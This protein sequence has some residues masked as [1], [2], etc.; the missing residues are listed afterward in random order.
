MS[1]P[2]PHDGGLLDVQATLLARLKERI[3][4]VE[5]APFPARPDQY[6]LTHRVGALLVAYSGSRYGDSQS[7]DAV[8][9]VREQRWDINI[10]ARSLGD[11]SDALRLL[12]RA[13]RAVTGLDLDAGPTRPVSEQ[14]LSHDEGV[15]TYALTV[16]VPTLVLEVIDV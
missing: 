6:R 13:R 7:T 4:G 1:E 11:T 9:Q 2:T 12:D 3:S 10:V 14:F 16:A 5:I 15:W 8:I